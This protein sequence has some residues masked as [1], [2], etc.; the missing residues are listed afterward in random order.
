MEAGGTKS[1]IVHVQTTEHA[2]KR[3]YNG[4]KLWIRRGRNC[5]FRKQRTCRINANRYQIR[6]HY[7]FGNKYSAFKRRHWA[8]AAGQCQ[9]GNGNL[10]EWCLYTNVVMLQGPNNNKVLLGTID[11]HMPTEQS[12]V[13]CA[14]SS[15]DNT[16]F[17][18][19]NHR[20]HVDPSKFTP[21]RTQTMV[22]RVT[23]EYPSQL[24]CNW[25]MD[26][27]NALSLRALIASLL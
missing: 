6:I 17:L 15:N 20:Q 1:N 25:L 11:E 8:V 23:A 7:A 22:A 12:S 26:N 24:N 4:A 13:S 18:L 5:N 3:I 10:L 2:C 9:F 16:R 21:P 14:W 27:E 19:A